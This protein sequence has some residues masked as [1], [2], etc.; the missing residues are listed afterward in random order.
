MIRGEEG[1]PF[2]ICPTFFLGFFFFLHFA[3]SFK[4]TVVEKINKNPAVTPDPIHLP[5]WLRGRR[6]GREIAPTPIQLRTLL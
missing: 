1:M 6:G 4:T 2:L 5:S 3:L